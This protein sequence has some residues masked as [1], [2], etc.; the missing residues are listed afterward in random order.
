MNG[1]VIIFGDILRKFCRSNERCSVCA[2]CFLI[3]EF[4][5][6]RDGFWKWLCVV[7]GYFEVAST[8]TMESNETIFSIGLNFRVILL[9]FLG[10]G[11]FS[12]IGIRFN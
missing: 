9:L 10:N 7:F 1:F 5:F 12:S 6:L 4:W 8:M 11:N 2:E 3:N